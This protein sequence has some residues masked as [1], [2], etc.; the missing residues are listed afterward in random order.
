MRTCEVCKAAENPIG[1]LRFRKHFDGLVYCEH[2]I[3][4]GSGHR[5]VPAPSSISSAT[6]TSAGSLV[7]IPCPDCRGMSH[8]PHG[9]P[10]ETCAGYGSVRIRENFLNEYRPRARPKP[11]Q[12][13]ED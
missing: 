5:E 1:R 11:Q 13:T 6:S 10:C 9:N 12:L 3:P 7:V 4:G 8:K 2:C